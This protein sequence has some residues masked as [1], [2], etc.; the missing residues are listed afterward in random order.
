MKNDK[1]KFYDC[2]EKI[3][4]TSIKKFVKNFVEDRVPDYFWRIPASSSGKYH[5]DY[6]LGKGGLVRHTIAVFYIGKELSDLEQYDFKQIRR[7][8]ILA[9]LL[10]HDT[11]K[12]GKKE[13][14]HTCKKHPVICKEEILDYECPNSFGFI[15]ERIADM[16]ASHMGQWNTDRNDNVVRP[17][18]DNDNKNFVHLCDYLASRKFLEF[19]FDKVK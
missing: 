2:V 19:N 15:K 8:G 9:A 10:L 4:I 3:E 5:P 16:V 13:Q 14:K 17:K 12:K 11:F 18:P 6:S 7:D 1:E